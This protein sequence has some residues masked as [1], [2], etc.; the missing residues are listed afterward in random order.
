MSVALRIFISAHVILSLHQKK[1]KMTIKSAPSGTCFLY[2]IRDLDLLTSMS[3]V[4]V[5]IAIG[6][7]TVYSEF[8]YP[9]DGEIVL[10]DLAGIFQPYARQQLVI[11]AVITATEQ[12]VDDDGNDGSCRGTA[13]P[14]REPFFCYGK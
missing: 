9:A 2:N 4:L 10:A 11:D 7:N 6:D 8:L 12:K 14:R 13:L 3:R 5:T 1:D